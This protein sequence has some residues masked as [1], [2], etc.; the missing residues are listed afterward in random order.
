M[1][2]VCDALVFL[3]AHRAR[4]ANDRGVKPE[5]PTGVIMQKRDGPKMRERKKDTKARE[6]I[7]QKETNIRLHPTEPPGEPDRAQLKAKVQRSKRR[8]QANVGGLFRIRQTPT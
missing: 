3:R 5:R 6:R 4:A 2:V 8:S 1:S 7:K